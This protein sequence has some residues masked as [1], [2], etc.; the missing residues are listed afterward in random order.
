MDGHQGG[1]IMGW[2]EGRKKGGKG[3]LIFKWFGG[4]NGLMDLK[5]E[6]H[7]DQLVRNQSPPFSDKQV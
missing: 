2:M 3:N 4:K 1:W 7:Q 5:T 6:I